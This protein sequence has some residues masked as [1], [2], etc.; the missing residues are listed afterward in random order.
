MTTKAF[1][2][3]VDTI[4]PSSDFVFAGPTAMVST[5][6]DQALVG[7]AE[8]SIGQH[9]DTEALVDVSMCYQ[10]TEAGTQPLNI[11]GGGFNFSQV[12]LTQDLMPVP[13]AGA[14]IPGA[15]TWNVGMCVQNASVVNIDQNDFVNGWVEVVNT[16]GPLS[17]AASTSAQTR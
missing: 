11:F 4:V 10:S 5:A 13:A 16:T 8:A 7:S 3:Q 1:F 14:V 15:G 12:V 17:S 2:G 9:A 6:A